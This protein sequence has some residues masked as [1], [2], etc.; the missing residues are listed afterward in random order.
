MNTAFKRILIIFSVA[1][2]IGFVVMAACHHF[3]IHPEPRDER[4]WKEL[5]TI[6]EEMTLPKAQETELLKSMTEFKKKVEIVNR[7]IRQARKDTLIFLSK[8]L[9]L[10]EQLLH[11]TFEKTNSLY[12]ERQK[13][14][15]SHI[16]RL[17]Q[18]LGEEKGVYFFQRILGNKK[19]DP[20]DKG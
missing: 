12:Q 13:L 17:H 9:P 11:G 18:I 20:G 19:S 7:Q 2:N 15:E 8:A 10:D 4:H 16:V 6:V 14:F 3:G 5:M 1:L